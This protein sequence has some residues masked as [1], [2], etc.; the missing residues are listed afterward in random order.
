M[1]PTSKNHLLEND[2]GLGLKNFCEYVTSVCLMFGTIVSNMAFIMAIACLMGAMTI[3]IAL[4]IDL[5][6][7][8]WN[9]ENG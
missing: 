1:L 4:S 5:Y 2:D 8:L 6:K 3:S 9:S 7:S